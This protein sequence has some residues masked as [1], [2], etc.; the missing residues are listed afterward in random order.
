MTPRPTAPPCRE[1]EGT[2]R[3]GAPVGVSL[4]AIVTLSTE[5]IGQPHTWVA[6]LLEDGGT[7]LAKAEGEIIGS[8]GIEV[9]QRAG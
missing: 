3:V 6:E 2:G 1:S 9:G 4:A 7:S 8:S 5:E